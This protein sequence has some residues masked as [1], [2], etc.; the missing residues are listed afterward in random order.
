MNDGVA[1]A[2]TRNIVASF[3]PEFSAIESELRTAYI[4]ENRTNRAQTSADA[5][6]DRIKE[7]ASTF[8]REAAA[9]RAEI[10]TVPQPVSRANAQMTGLPGPIL[11]AVFSASEGEVLALP[12]GDGEIFLV[13][14]VN[15]VRLPD[16]AALRELQ[17]QARAGLT[18]ALGNDIETAMSSEIRSLMRPQINERGLA[19]YKRSIA[20]RQ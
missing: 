10:E 17:A 4:S 5:L 9:A 12:L 11:Q 15:E 6:K 3:T 20:T 2:S 14:R 19:D 1:V 18:S 13:L 7:G 8:E 16:E